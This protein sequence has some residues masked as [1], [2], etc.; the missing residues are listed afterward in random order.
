M[1]ASITVLK[2]LSVIALV[3][4]IALPLQAQDADQNIFWAGGTGVLTDANYNTAS[5]AT[6]GLTPTTTD[7]VFFGSTGVGTLDGPVT[8]TVNRLRIGHTN[9][10]QGGVGTVT[11]SNGAQINILSGAGSPG[12]AGLM[13]GN[14]QDGELIIDGVGSS[15]TSARVISIGVSANQPTRSGTVRLTNGGSLTATAG[16]IY[17]GW[18][19]T[20]TATNPGQAGHLII[21]DGTLSGA[22]GM[23]IGAHDVTSTFTQQAGTVNLVGAVEVGPPSSGTANSSTFT[24]SGGSFTNGG[25]FFVG[26]GAA[27]NPTVNIAGGTLNVGGRFLAGGTKVAENVSPGNATGITVNHS[28]GTLSTGLNLVVA[29][30]APTDAT[31]NLSGTGVINATTGGIVGRQGTGKFVQTGGQAN[32]MDAFSIGNREA[33]ALAANGLYKISA[34][35]FNAGAGLSPAT[36]ALNIAPNGTGEFRVV[37]DDASINVLGLM[38]IGNSENGV[39]TLAFEFETGDLLSTINAT[40]A[41]TF[42]LG[43]KLVLDTT[44]ASATA[45]SYDLLTAP[46]IDNLGFDLVAPAGWSVEIVSGGSGQILR[47]VNAGGG[48]FLS[49]D[50]NED[51]QVNEVDLNTWK[52]AFGVSLAGDANNDGVTNGNDFLVW[53]RQRGMLPPAVAATAPATA[54]VPEPASLVLA[55]G[56]VLVASQPLRRHALRRSSNR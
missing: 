41:T 35:E 47:A 13:V 48:S 7:A 17:V 19:T 43:S 1:K 51:G 18:R 2:L 52:G 46:L 39:G 16:P 49:A 28:A 12:D 44:N 8:L 4:L 10:T 14:G 23:T 11:V 21:E 42:A 33:A 25:N 30:A 54:A 22:A 6:T 53:Q 31:Y 32:F 36:M 15:V 20:N 56:I 34:G 24:I 50:F 26:R 3:A 38:S 55:L 9:A 5:N 27:T 40:S 45:T 37:G 29:D